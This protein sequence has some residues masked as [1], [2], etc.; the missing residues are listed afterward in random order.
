MKYNKG[1]IGIGMIIA[2]VAALVVVGG[3]A[4]YFATKTPTPASQNIGENNYQPQENQNQNGVSNTPVQN[5]VTNNTANQQTQN[6]NPSPSPTCKPSITVLS[7]NGGETY[8]AGQQ[9]TIKWKTCNLSQ[10]VGITLSGF[11]YP[12]DIQFFL[13]NWVASSIGSQIVTIP[14][15]AQS[16]KYIINISTPPESSPSAEDWSNNYF[17]IKVQGNPIL[18][19][20]QAETLVHKTWSDCSQG[21]CGGVTVTVVQ[22]SSGQ[23]VVTAIFT[24][25]DDSTS[26]TKRVS[27]ATYQNGIWM[28]GQPT[29]TRTCHRG[30]AD[31]TTGWTAGLCI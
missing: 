4:V 3:G 12:N 28:L 29:I 5:T 23:Y 7:P 26:Q 31:G 20:T 10:S 21:D 9:I 25:L 19:Q 22:N 15:T 6:N 27:I 17:T 13:G 30:N 2:I 11:P 18:T 16:G 1:F 24:E 14:S 8:V